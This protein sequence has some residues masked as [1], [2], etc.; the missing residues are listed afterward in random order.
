[1]K[2]GFYVQT[3]ISVYGGVM[4]A[5]IIMIVEMDQMNYI[6]MVSVLKSGHLSNQ[7]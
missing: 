2:I 7:Y 5:M 1:M 3:P 4:Y 6:V